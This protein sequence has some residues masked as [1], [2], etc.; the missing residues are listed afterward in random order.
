M[1]ASLGFRLR[2]H[3]QFY[4]AGPIASKQFFE[5]DLIETKLT[6][7]NVVKKCEM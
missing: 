3:C 6:V 5:K 7:I 4:N 2:Q 1:L